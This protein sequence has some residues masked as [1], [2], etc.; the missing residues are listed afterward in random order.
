MARRAPRPVALLLAGL[1]AVT[2]DAAASPGPA[3]GEPLHSA[4]AVD[5]AYRDAGT[6]RLWSDPAR[7]AAL[8]AAV[9]AAAA[10]GLRSADYYLDTLEALPP[11]GP[12]D[13]DADR[14]ATDAF[15]TL[16]SHLALGKVD[17]IQLEPTW[18][19]PRSELRQRALGEA[20]R[21][22]L[23]SGRILEAA[24]AARPHHYLY[25]Q[26][27]AALARYR[28]IAAAG[29]W[30]RVGPG[31][32]LAPGAHDA[33]IPRLRQRLAIEDG[34]PATAGDDHYDAALVDAVR[35]FQGRHGLPKDGV[36]GDATIRELDVPVEARVDTLRL[37][38]ERGRWVL[39][40]IGEGDLVVVD[41]AGFGVRYVRDRRVIWRG[42]AI[43]GRRYRQTP[44]FR[45]EISRVVLN[46]TWTV[47]P[48]ILAKDVL[49]ALA[50]G[51]DALAHKHLDV[52]DRA[53][54]PVDPGGIDWSNA[55]AAHFPYVLRQAA[56]EANALG[57][58]KIDFDNPYAVY[59]H[60]TPSRE[61][62][63][64]DERAFS[65][66]CIR[67]D[68]PV[69]FAALVLGEPSRWSAASLQAIIDAGTTRTIPLARKVPILVMY[70]TAEA[71]G[72]G[73]VTFRRDLYGRDARLL[74]ELDPRDQG[75]GKRPPPA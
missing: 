60:D 7:R 57:R 26:G 17:P 23:A 8:L 22:A 9:R 35:A 53:G 32:K 43:V 10:E 66:G 51:E 55:S 34:L 31:T 46:P 47:P 45:A 44:V 40:D 65:S 75:R 72:D 56:G 73:L 12:L 4:A 27:R 36:L 49:P 24:E 58:V 54:H 69:E 18:R 28:A 13:E 1:L 29:G 20:I 5:T 30:P 33:R 38:L 74:R 70:W 71:G 25:E 63:S 19:L 6:P 15:V 68:R 21:A 39:D 61:L 3:P 62:F 59:L 14:I 16:L 52:Y 64:R 11:A 42:R 50:R 2:A 37:N 41:I 48:S 67:I